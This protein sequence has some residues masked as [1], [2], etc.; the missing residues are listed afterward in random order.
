MDKI[1]VKDYKK[2][3]ICKS[4]YHNKRFKNKYGSWDSKAEFEYFLILKDKEKFGQIK[5]LRR[6]VSIEI[7]PSFKD[8]NGKTIKAITYKADFVYEDQDGKKHIVDV[9]GMKTDVYKLKK[10]MLLYKG[11]EIEEVNLV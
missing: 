7:Q 3:I 8:S 10:K 11:I 6:Q 4:K 1:S 2:L 9:K 5:N